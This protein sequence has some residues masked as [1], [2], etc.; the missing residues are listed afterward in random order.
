MRI[1]RLFGAFA[2]L[3][4]CL[5]LAACEKPEEKAARYLERG[6]SF[7]EKGAYEKARVEYKNAARLKPAD[8]DLRYRLGLVEEAE[9][10]F[11]AAFADFLRAEEQDVHFHPAALKLAKYYLIGDQ[12]EQARHRLDAVLADMPDDAEARALHGSLLLHEKK[13]EEAEKEARFATQKDPANIT[14]YAVLV[15]L[16]TEQKDDAKAEAAANEGLKHN[17]DDLSLLLMKASIYERRGDLDMLTETYKT[18]FKLKPQ[19]GRFRADLAALYLK[20]GKADE[21]EKTMRDAIAVLP[22]DWGLKFRLVEFLDAQ[23]G[24]EAAEKEVRG[25]MQA[26]PEKDDLYQWLVDLYLRHNATDRAVTLLGQVI[27][28]NKFEKQGIEARAALARINYGGGHSQEA[29]K[30]ATSVLEKEE[31]NP[32]ALLIRAQLAADQGRYENAVADLR[33]ILR[34]RPKTKDALRLLSETLFQQGHPNLAIDTLNQLLDT[35]PTDTAARTRLAQLYHLSGDTKRA[36]SLLFLVTKADPSYG[37]A[38]ESIARIAIDTKDMTTAENA[39][40]TLYKLEGQHAAAAFMRGEFLNATDKP[41]DALALYKEVIAIDP[42]GSLAERA[43]AAFVTTQKKLNRMQDAA[44]YIAGLATSSPLTDTVLAECYVD[45]GKPDLAAAR[46]DK[47]IAAH[48]TRVETYI[49]RANLFIDA[50][51]PEA[52][53]EALKKG[54]QVAPSDLRL[55]VMQ[56]QLLLNTQRYNEA[57]AIYSDLL[58]RNPEM[59]LAANNLAAIIANYQYTDTA[60]LDKARHAAERFVASPNPLLL[61]TL[62]WV[63]YRQGK[64]VEAQNILERALAVSGTAASPEMHYHYGATLLKAGKTTEARS[65]LQKAVADGVAAYPGLED[66]KKLLAGL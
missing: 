23:R 15:A 7:F 20:A 62:G 37:V 17:P 64:L 45:L 40:A 29:E 8:A 9:N 33:T 14:G 28:K 59:D 47:A 22:D 55:P 19:E 38:W 50:H 39:V 51:Q 26:H 5:S 53:I 36:M 1:H 65:A 13:Y 49:D 12:Y 41:E 31:D 2:L 46:L 18:L 57:V 48:S 4:L 60:A 3:A 58:A 6:N 63:Y 11:L 42:A 44:D 10:N 54:L 35:D 43:L 16:A 66:A 30:L 61:D 52:A 24:L 32:Q 34:A 21:A 56:A 25:Y 27:E